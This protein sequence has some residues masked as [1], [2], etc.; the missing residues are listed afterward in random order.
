[1][2]REDTMDTEGRRLVGLLMALL[3]S[4]LIGGI[5]GWVLKPCPCD[6]KPVAAEI[7]IDTVTKVIEHEPLLVTAPAVVRFVRD[8]ITH[9]DTIIQTRPFVARLDTVVRRDTLGVEYRFPQH[10]FA[11]LLRQAPDS[12]RYETR[13]LTLTSYERRAW[14]L[15]A[16]THVGAASLGYAIGSV[17]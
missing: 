8:T 1:M 10:T 11:V 7:R 14:W 5:L 9:T 3:M 15:D 2:E 13:T 4:C 16:L 17:R 6:Q 12:I